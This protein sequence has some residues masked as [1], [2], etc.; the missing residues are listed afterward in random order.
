VGWFAVGVA[1]AIFIETLV[2][3]VAAATVG[4]VCFMLIPGLY[5][6][7]QAGQDA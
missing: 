7:R 2:G 4:I 3:Y 6:M 5:L 1:M